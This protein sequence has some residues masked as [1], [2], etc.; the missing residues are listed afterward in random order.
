[1]KKVLM[2][3]SNVGL[4][5]EELQAPWDALKKAGHDLTLATHQG[6][7]PLPLEISMDPDFIDPFQHYNVNP[8]EV[9]ERTEEILQNGEWDDVIKIE[10]ARM[11]DYDAVVIV[12]G[13]GSALDL[14]GN[15][16]VHEL[17]VDAYTA[18]KP[19]GAL[20]YAVG[21]LIWARKPEDGKSIIWGRRV[22]AHPAAWD[23][24]ADMG[25][26]LHGS[27]D[28]NAGTDL[29]TRGFV[30]PL[31]VVVEDAVGPDGRVESDPSTNRSAPLVVVDYPFVTALSVESSIAFGD[32]LVEVMASR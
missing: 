12:G 30:F 13:P 26:T 23:F 8:R 31:Q 10:D 19:I 24:K 3:A 29:V 21:C 25:Y 2:M 20:C 9:V 4:W 5:A 18:G 16:D 14:V 7:T 15:P 17:L 27:S 11:S 6:R 28:G 32:A 22:A 1:M